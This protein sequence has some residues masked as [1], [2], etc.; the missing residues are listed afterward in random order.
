MSSFVPVYNLITLSK[1]YFRI[2]W[3][4][5][6][7]CQDTSYYIISYWGWYFH[8]VDMLDS[9][10][11]QYTVCQ[12]NLQFIK[13]TGT[14]IIL[15]F[16]KDRCRPIHIQINMWETG[17]IFPYT[18]CQYYIILVIFFFMEMYHLL[19]IKCGMWWIA[20][21][22]YNNKQYCALK[23]YI[24]SANHCY[25]YSTINSLGIAQMKYVMMT[26]FLHVFWMEAFLCGRLEVNMLSIYYKTAVW[27][28]NNLKLV[29]NILD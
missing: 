28:V 19:N 7:S 5:L 2:T 4:Y 22:V 6:A 9:M 14:H 27:L 8:G 16:I 23:C 3:H 11:H 24:P 13:R 18:S 26:G 25:I 1:C 12:V 20:L 17:M 29:A 10:M 21:S 15:L